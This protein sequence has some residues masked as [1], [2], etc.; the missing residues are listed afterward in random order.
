MKLPPMF[1]KYFNVLIFSALV[2]NASVLYYQDFSA[3]SP[4]SEINGSIPDKTLINESRGLKRREVIAG[5]STLT[6]STNGYYEITVLNFE[7]ESA[8]GYIFNEAGYPGFKSTDTSVLFQSGTVTFTYGS[9][10]FRGKISVKAASFN[11]GQEYININSISLIQDDT[12]GE[13]KLV[14]AYNAYGDFMPGGTESIHV[15]T[16]FG[17]PGDFSGDI[18]ASLGILAPDSAIKQTTS[19][20]IIAPAFGRK[21]VGIPESSV[22]VLIAGIMALTFSMACRRKCHSL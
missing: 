8:D 20:I 5:G 16:N 19:N 6:T 3:S 1:L 7:G 11:V 4:V 17:I 9:K 10:V 18:T 12:S 13:I 21:P 15:E 14:I 2:S 22:F